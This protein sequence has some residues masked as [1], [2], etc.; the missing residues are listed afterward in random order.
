MGLVSSGL[1][2]HLRLLQ[3]DLQV[4][5]PS[6]LGLRLALWLQEERRN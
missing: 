6:A 3:V 5:R 4:G 2:T 1:I